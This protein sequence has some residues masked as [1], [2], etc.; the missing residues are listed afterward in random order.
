M[1]LS[2]WQRVRTRLFLFL[3]ALKRRLTLGVRAVLIDGDKVL[4]IRQTYLPGWHFPGGGVEPHETAETAAAREAAEETGYRVEGRPVLH[5]L[6]FN[7]SLGSDRDHVAVYVW[8]RFA[9]GGPFRPN[10]EVADC[11]W[12][13]SDALPSDV[14]TGTAARIREIF[15]GTSPPAEWEA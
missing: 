8:R 1:Q 11:Q 15:A 2:L 12:F 7:R 3:V 9:S 6:F 13:A 14:E 5:G 4:L 10:L